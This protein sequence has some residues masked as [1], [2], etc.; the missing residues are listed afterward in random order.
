MLIQSALEQATVDR[1]VVAALAV[2][3]ALVL[4]SAVCQNTL[5]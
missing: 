1:A 5:R 4:P 2:V 3:G